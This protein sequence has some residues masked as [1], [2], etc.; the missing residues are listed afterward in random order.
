[1]PTP[2][3]MHDKVALVTGAAA[4]LGRAT[5]LELARAGASLSLLDINAQGLEETAAMVRELGARAQVQAI[6]LSETAQCA[7]AVAAAVEAYGRLDALCNVAAV[8]IPRHSA[9]MTDDELDT[10]LAVNLAAPFKLI[11]AAI[12]HLLET[13]GAVVN[14][15]SC[16]AFM[17]QAYLAAY[18]ATKAGLTHMTKSLAMEY[19]HQPIRFNA[20]APGGMMTALAMGLTKLEDPDPSLLGRIAPLRGLVEV[21]DVAQMVA[22]LATDAA[23]GYHGAC[24]NIDNGI[25][26]G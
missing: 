22:F 26:A 4:G 9:A 20:V 8:F 14:V 10:T 23:R 11:R 6:D 19:M 12:P 5:A 7:P 2:S 18:S 17:G 13:H 15:T 21:E 24:I 25:T 3:D 1:M 16:A